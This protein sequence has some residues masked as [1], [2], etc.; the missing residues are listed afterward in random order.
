MSQ[1]S[2]V[3][4]LVHRVLGPR[5]VGVYSH[6]SAVLGGLRPHSDVD[7]FVLIAERTTD[8]ERR[9]L[10]D[11]LLLLSSPD[12]RTGVRPVE[13][14]V[15][16][17]SDV[18]PWRYPPRREFQY[19][20]WLRDSYED[21][22]TPSPTSDPDLALLI[23]MVLQA[24]SPLSGPS[25]GEVLPPVPREDIVKALVAGVP[26][27]LD[28][29][30]S[31]TRNVVLTLARIWLTLETGTI[32]SKEAAADWALPRLPSDHRPVLVHAC[33]VYRGDTEEHW[34][35]FTAQLEPFAA[36]IVQ[37][38]NTLVDDAAER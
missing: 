26:E 17:R 19:G 13:L 15:A 27:L 1:T 38:I 12:A 34:G 3:I 29:L 11:G 21:G 8:A 24:D 22:W 2:D 9:E 18:R 4:T 5:V 10:V 6:G 7:V 35:D 32:G 20:E 30:H 28:E 36:R 16:V 23:T 33:A 37:A 25:P 14:T 31:D